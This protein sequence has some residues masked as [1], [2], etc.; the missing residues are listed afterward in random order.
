MCVS[1]PLIRKQFNL[2]PLSPSFPFLPPSRI[3]PKWGAKLQ[4]THSLLSPYPGRPRP[5]FVSAPLF[6]IPSCVLK[7]IPCAKKI[8]YFF[9]SQVLFCFCFFGS[10]FIVP[11]RSPLSPF[12]SFYSSKI[13]PAPILYNFILVFH[14]HYAS[15]LITISMVAPP[16]LFSLFIMSPFFC[17][18]FEIFWNYQTN[19]SFLKT[20]SSLNIFL[21]NV[22]KFVS[23]QP[24]HI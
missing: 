17:K 11:A 18:S 16:S 12:P 23:F 14:T 7:T 19:F 10:C 2:Y 24:K 8:L 9:V 6:Q 15:F 22:R 1:C 13:S 3:A 21:K 4:N 20:C 5:L